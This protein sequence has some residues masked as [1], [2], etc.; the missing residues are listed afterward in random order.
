MTA[1]NAYPPLRREVRVACDRDTAFDLFTAHIGAW[2]PMRTHSVYGEEATVAFENG[3][4]I[5]RLGDRETVW[6]TVLEWDRPAGFGM[7][8]HPGNPPEQATEV[9]VGFADAGTGTLVTLTHVGWDR[10]GDADRARAGYEV[11]WPI[12]LGEYEQHAALAQRGSANP[13]T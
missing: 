11:G 8:W 7:T 3:Q 10:R 12:V 1:A 9:H 4:V 13:V 2:W 5:E 6:G